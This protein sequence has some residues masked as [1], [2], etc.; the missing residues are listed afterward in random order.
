MVADPER[1]ARIAFPAPYLE[2][3]AS[4]AVRAEAPFRN[5]ADLDPP[6]LRI[7]AGNKAAYDFHFTRTLRHAA[8]ERAPDQGAALRLFIV[9]GL[10]AG[11]RQALD[12][13]VTEHPGMCILPDRL[14]AIGQ[15]MAVPRDGGPAAALVE[16]FFDGLKASGA[17]GGVLDR[18][19]PSS[20]SIPA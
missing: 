10:G 19:A 7:A 8:I 3:E 12:A 14:M 15:C 20:L 16:A 4:Y 5:C 11:V 13:F 9:G 2:I 18:N 6:G 17:L 1:A